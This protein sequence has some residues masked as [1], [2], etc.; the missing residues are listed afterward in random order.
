MPATQSR[1]VPREI[2][3]FLCLLA[4]V[5]RLAFSYTASTVRA[6]QQHPDS[7]I[8]PFG[9]R[10][11]AIWNASQGVG[12]RRNTGSAERSVQRNPDPFLVYRQRRPTARR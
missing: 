9:P 5:Y 1:H 7:R 6:G 8:R 10:H 2:N 3:L 4:A 12:G 11:G